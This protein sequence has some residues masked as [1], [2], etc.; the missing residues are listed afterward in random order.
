MN[1]GQERLSEAAELLEE[2]AAEFRE[3]ILNSHEAV[4]I[5]LQHSWTDEAGEQFGQKMAYEQIRLDDLYAKL[6][7]A[8]LM[9][10]KIG[11][12]HEYE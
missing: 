12:D 9:A 3:S 6:K 2:M 11:T 5:S 8:A 7:R 1:R 4:R 10:E